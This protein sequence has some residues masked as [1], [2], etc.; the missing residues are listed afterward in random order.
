LITDL[1]AQPQ[2]LD[3]YLWWEVTVQITF[4]RPFLTTADNAWKVRRRHQGYYCF[5]ASNNLIRAEDDL[6]AESVK[7]VPL[8]ATGKQQAGSVDP[9]WLYFEVYERSTFADM[10][11]GV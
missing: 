9:V 10:N 2:V 5:D 1:Q 4:R 11:L 8:D 7:P 3:N 6:G